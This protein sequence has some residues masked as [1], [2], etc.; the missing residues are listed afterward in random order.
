MGFWAFLFFSFLAGPTLGFDFS[1][2]LSFIVH[3]S[4]EPVGDFIFFLLHFHEFSLQ[5]S[6]F[7]KAAGER[8]AEELEST[9]ARQQQLLAAG[10]IDE[11]EMAAESGDGWAEA[12]G[13]EKG[14][15]RRR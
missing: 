5:I 2:L 8:D 13:A 10:E 14:R 1:K 15:R 9:P 6:F 3:V 7:F 12:N 11:G 4:I